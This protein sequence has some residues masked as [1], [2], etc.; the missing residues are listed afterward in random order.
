MLRPL[1]SHV[2][3]FV[4]PWTVA[5]QAPLSMGLSK[6]DYGVGCHFLPQ[7][8]FPPG[9]W[10]CI[11]CG[12]WT[13]G[14]FFTAESQRKPVRTPHPHTQQNILSSQLCLFWF[15]L[16]LVGNLT[17]KYIKTKITNKWDISKISD[18]SWHS[19]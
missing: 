14:G 12:S 19:T 13:A 6:Q 2:W 17:V 8:I 10:I 1:L 11:S 15:F 9:D 4:T 7:G 3:L 18:A 16:H 5:H